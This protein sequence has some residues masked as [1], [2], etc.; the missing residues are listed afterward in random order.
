[1]EFEQRTQHPQFIGTPLNVSE[2][3]KFGEG[4]VYEYRRTSIKKDS[5]DPY[6]HDLARPYT[7]NTIFARGVSAFN[8]EDI[9]DLIVFLVNHGSRNFIIRVIDETRFTRNTTTAIKIYDFLVSRQTTFLLQINGEKFDYVADYYSKLREKFVQSEASSL[10]KSRISKMTHQKLK[11]TRKDRKELKTHFMRMMFVIGK[12]IDGVSKIVQE[13]GLRG[14]P[15]HKLIKFEKENLREIQKL[16]KKRKYDY[17]KCQVTGD[18]FV[19]PRK[20]ARATEYSFAS[21]GLGSSDVM[22]N[23]F[24]ENL[25]MNYLCCSKESFPELVVNEAPM[26]AEPEGMFDIVQEAE[27]EAEEE[28]LSVDEIKWLV[29]IYNKQYNQGTITVDELTTKMARLFS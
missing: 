6:H 2:G 1:M 11:K 4:M 17:A 24:T 9:Y 12:D 29:E 14:M 27:A 16:K 28:K 5:T 20:Y 19:V 8:R 25:G 15:K 26:E 3:I 23:M 13:S 18:Y 7:H 10:E 21:L 22:K